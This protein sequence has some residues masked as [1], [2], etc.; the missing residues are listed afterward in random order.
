MRLTIFFLRREHS[1]SLFVVEHRHPGDHCPARDPQMASMLLAHLSPASAQKHGLT[2]Q[3]EAVLN[4]GHALYLIVDG[5]DED[6][7]NRF[8]QPFAR[9]GSVQV[10]PASHC[11]AVVERGGC[12]AL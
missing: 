1:M 8:M 7:V 3:A 6:S 5:P 12:D 9:A 2:I 11:E 4:S 10:L